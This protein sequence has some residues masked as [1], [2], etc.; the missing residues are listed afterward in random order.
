VSSAAGLSREDVLAQAAASTVSG[1]F[2]RASEVADLVVFLAGD[3]ADNIL[4]SD[5]RIDGG[6][7]PTW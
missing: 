7:V 3:R 5:F 4:G 1:R 2:S 6:F